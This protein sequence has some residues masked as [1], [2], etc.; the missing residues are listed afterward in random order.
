MN[1]KT[2]QQ[3]LL[4]FA[5]AEARQWLC[6]IPHLERRQVYARILKCISDKFDQHEQELWQLELLE[7][8]DREYTVRINGD[9]KDTLLIRRKSQSDES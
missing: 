9:L 2:L 7:I 4:K 8:A 1:E 6:Q 5:L 3:Q